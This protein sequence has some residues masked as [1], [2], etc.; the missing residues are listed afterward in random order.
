[1]FRRAEDADARDDAALVSERRQ[2]FDEQAIG[3]VAAPMRRVVEGVLRQQDSHAAYALLLRKRSS[4]S[5]RFS[6]LSASMVACDA[7]SFSRGASNCRKRSISAAFN[8]RTKSWDAFR[9]AV[10]SRSYSARSP[11]KRSRAA[12]QGSVSL[13]STTGFGIACS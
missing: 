4:S 9:D 12:T 7:P 3:L 1:M 11:S 6:G 10:D 5:A 2:R 8:P 13:R